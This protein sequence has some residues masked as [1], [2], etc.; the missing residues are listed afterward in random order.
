MTAVSTSYT[1]QPL[2]LVRSADGA[3][4]GVKEASTCATAGLQIDRPMTGAHSR[5]ET[6]Y[7]L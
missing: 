7:R 2:M 4:A 1:A 6:D 3:L 5:G